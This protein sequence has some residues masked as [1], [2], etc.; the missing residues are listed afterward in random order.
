MEVYKPKKRINVMVADEDL[1]WVI[2]VIL[3]YWK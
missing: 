2:D 3:K 1:E